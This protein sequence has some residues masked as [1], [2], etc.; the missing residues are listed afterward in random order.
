MFY[1]VSACPGIR[2]SAAG[3]QIKGKRGTTSANPEFAVECFLFHAVRWA[4]PWDEI[5]RMF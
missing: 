1:T 2:D 5:S 4:T 3:T